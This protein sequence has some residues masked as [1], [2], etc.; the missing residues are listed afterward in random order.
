M[1]PVSAIKTFFAMVVARR[2]GELIDFE[3]AVIG[4]GS[5]WKVGRETEGAANVRQ[6]GF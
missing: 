2:P 3:M 4:S 5:P 6:A 1:T